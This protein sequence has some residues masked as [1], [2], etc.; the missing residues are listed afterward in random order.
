MVA[1]V[2]VC[3]KVHETKIKMKIKKIVV[4]WKKSKRQSRV[5]RNCNDD[6]Q[7]MLDG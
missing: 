5:C 1:G 7:I 6:L 4:F 3:S 2:W